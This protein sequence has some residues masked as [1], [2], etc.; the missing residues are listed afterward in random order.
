MHSIVQSAG[1]AA[2][3]TT[4]QQGYSFF[5]C[6]TAATN[7]RRVRTRL[8][9]S[10]CVHVACANRD[11][12]LLETC[13]ACSSVEPGHGL[14][15]WRFPRNMGWTRAWGS[16]ETS[17][18]FLEYGPGSGCAPLS[19]SQESD[20]YSVMRNIISGKVCRSLQPYWKRRIVESPV[21]KIPTTQRDACRTPFCDGTCP[22][23]LKS[24]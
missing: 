23:R 4:L 17:Q 12:R 20:V 21:L 16:M 5:T 19:V 11:R 9:P 10:R 18:L 14:S 15:G 2:Y 6:R 13:S 3:R 1:L 7:S 22:S 24:A 8:A